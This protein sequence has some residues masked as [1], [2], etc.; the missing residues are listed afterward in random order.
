M[1]YKRPYLGHFELVAVTRVYVL[2]KRPD[3]DLDTQFELADGVKLDRLYKPSEY[4]ELLINPPRVI[5]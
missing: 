5:V 2:Q 4:A 3:G 1:Y